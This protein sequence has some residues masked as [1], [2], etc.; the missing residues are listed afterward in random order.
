MG[1][2]G[3]TSKVLSNI[4]AKRYEGKRAE[5]AKELVSK[6]VETISEESYLARAG[7]AFMGHAEPA[8]HRQPRSNEKQRVKRANDADQRA[9]EFD[10][11]RS[12]LRAEYRAKV[13]R[14]EIKSPSA[15]DRLRQK[16][17]GHEDNESTR[18]ARRVLEKRAARRVQ[19]S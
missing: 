4:D 14:G 11:Q 19:N 5:R 13:E 8:L 12:R 1:G 10:A 16:T 2:R 9:R 17:Q 3:S 18:A 7:F 15:L 6:R